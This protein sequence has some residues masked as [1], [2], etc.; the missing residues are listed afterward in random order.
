VIAIIGI[1][2]ALLLP[3]VQAAREAARRSQCTNNLKQLALAMHNFHDTA[4]RF[5]PGMARDVPPF[6]T[7]ISAGA[8][9]NRGSAWMAYILPGI[10]QKPL[11]D[12]IQFYDNSGW[13]NVHDADVIADVEIPAFRCPS[14]PLPK[15]ARGFLANNRHSMNPSYYGISGAADTP[16]NDIIPNY[17]EKRINNI[18][19]IVSGGG[20]LF[21]NS[22]IT[23]GDIT[24]GSS[25]CLMIS[26]Q[27]N[28]I[29]TTDGA[30][31]DWTSA[32]WGWM[33][34]ASMDDTPPNYWSDSE[35]SVTTIRYPINQNSGWPVGGNC[36]GAGVCGDQACNIPLNSAHP[37]GVNGA[38]CDGSVRFLSQTMDLATLAELATRDDRIPL[39]NF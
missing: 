26:E 13:G 25:N 34:G 38:L 10:E 8:N 36:A 29:Y 3:A 20:V 21:P 37:G 23:F 7:G 24:D 30:Q 22:K 15:M 35:F 16:T 19:G 11:Y 2:I 6:G 14:S 1:L 31:N 5:P 32:T 4:K 9:G 18:V 28:W 17:V 39:A 12:Q 27:A 33:M